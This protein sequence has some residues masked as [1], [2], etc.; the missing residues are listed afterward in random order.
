M[1]IPP[2]RFLAWLR[3]LAVMAGLGALS[4]QA[5]TLAINNDVN[6]YATLTNTTVTMTGR[7]EL[8][9]T[10]TSNP[11]S[12]STIN[13]NSPDA[14]FF[15]TNIQPTVVV[16][17]YLGQVKVN[18]AAAAAGSNCRVV[19][20]GVGAVVIPQGPTFSPM[21]VYD[22]PQFSGPS[23]ALLPQTA[24]GSTELGTLNDAISSFKLKRGYTAT[25]A[26]NP[27][28]TGI[29]KNYVAADGD[30]EVSVL[31]SNLDNSVSFVR[32]FP[33]RWVN[34]KGSCDIDPV[35]L[36]AKWHYNWNIWEPS[37]S[38]DYEYV[39]IKQQPYWPGLNTSYMNSLG[40]S[41]LSG[42]NEPNNPV[43]DAYKNLN[44]QG[45]VSAAVAGFP[46]LLSTGLRV[47]T[48]AVTD[49]GY[50]WIVNFVNQANAAGYRIDYVP[51]HYYRSYPNNSYPAGA[52]GNLYNFLKSIYD[53]TGKPIWLTEFNNG[54]NWTTDP[55][56]D[57]AQNSNVI[58]AM[59]NMM[60][61][62]PWI[63]RYA[64]YS[65]VEEVRQVYYNAGGLTPM[66]VMYRDHV[67]PMAYRQALPEAGG[68]VSARYPFDDNFRD[69]LGNGNDAMAVGTPGF[70]AGKFGQA[71]TMDGTN[72]YLQLSNGVGDSVD[73]TF[74][75]WVKWNGG[76]NWQ[77]IFDFGGGVY[78]PNASQGSY[79]MLT[80]NNGSG[81]RFAITT[82]GYSNEQALTRSTP[83]PTGTWT[84][85]AV[86]I[87]GNTGKLF[88][89]GALVATNTGMT[90]NPVDIGTKFNYLGKSQYSG[91]PLFNGQLD[92][93]QILDYALTDAQVAALFS[94]G[95]PQFVSSPFS[96]PNASPLAPYSSSIAGYALDP[97]GQTVSYSK[98]SGP[99]WLSVAPDGRLFGIPAASDVGANTF[100]IRAQDPAG[101]VGT[102]TMTISVGAS[103]GLLV[104]Y[105]FDGT[106]APTAG[107]AESVATGSPAFTTGKYSQALNFD[108]S[109]DYLTLP[110]DLAST[111]DITVATWVYWN[112]GNAWQRIFDFGDT[113]ARSM[114]LTPSSGTG[115]LTFT[116][117]N[118]VANQSVESTGALPVR[119]W[120]HV[121]VTMNGDVGKLFV[122][123]TLVATNTGMTLNPVDLGAKTNYLGKSQWS[124]D[125]LFSGRLDEFTIFNYAL[126]DAGVAALFS[127]QPPSFNPA[128]VTGPA[129]TP[130]QLYRHS[131]AGAATDPEGGALSYSKL[132]GPQWL[133]ASPNGTLYG[134]PEDG[135][136]GLNTFRV[137][138]TDP[139][140]SSADATF[141]M[142]VGGNALVAEY[143]FN[144]NTNDN[145]GSNHGTASGSPAYVPGVFDQAISLNG[146][147][148]YVTLPA[149]IANSA[150]MTVSAR[151]KWNGG[152]AWQRVFD[153]GNDTNQHIYF[154][155][156]NSSG[157]PMFVIKNGS[158][159]D[160][161]ITAP[162]AFPIG[163]WTHV[164][165][166]LGG[167]TGAIYIDGT[168]VA[169]GAMT[170]AP[171]SFNPGVNYIGKSQFSADPLFNGQIDDLRI[172]SRALTDP[173][174][175][176]LATAA[177]TVNPNSALAYDNW[178]STIGFAAGQDGP[179]NDP[180]G[181]GESNVWELLTGS[182][183][184]VASSTPSS[185]GVD[186][187]AALGLANP[188]KTYLTMK[189]R[190]LKNRS[191][192][193]IVPR[194]AAT[195]LG[196]SDPASSANVSQ[197]GAPVDA[198]AFEIITYYLNMPLED[199]PA[200]F[201]RLDIGV[202]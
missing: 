151:V 157:A 100:L 39:A 144:G 1:M 43:E 135:D 111:S 25:I 32:I 155:P 64:I 23:K 168:K 57:F 137:R 128:S 65:A 50:S 84:H 158:G 27:D 141:S 48:P 38:R 165:V 3:C 175:S 45:S 191:G 189:P 16:S 44:P 4:A 150:A 146:T 156:R 96:A 181:D 66:G 132:L 178:A 33:W 193:S 122:N 187:A 180:D 184:L 160:Q 75:A 9:I 94:N 172:Y 54:A 41:H 169:S 199:S 127:N 133:T 90:F 161:I 81:M 31:P 56:P 5:Q 166:S 13:L 15:M 52:A 129:G 101:N 188:G 148:D 202:Q 88:V 28:G 53:A 83:L 74:A 110:G 126:S 8:R 200:G 134:R 36:N 69:L 79:L 91:D 40:V 11:I 47:G 19:Q 87:S 118:E 105:A 18:G 147:S 71:V 116:I 167:G 42:L 113:T 164:A 185:L 125:P 197:A 80:P 170:L 171:S 62:T 196:L 119:R 86:T 102:A 138:A 46:E 109:D 114:F 123:G 35:A 192:I 24:Y 139:A 115:T 173:E 85:V 117:Y 78:V 21:T 152:G 124:A 179:N 154:T 76:N 103:Q 162:G 49:G 68:S 107:V 112:G 136:V 58:E 177:F 6:S 183:P 63:E 72:D 82:S 92:D 2:S 17:T 7:S 142:N 195:L 120:T 60:D 70:A 12:G 97:E 34:K 77:R 51:I 159:T 37:P 55:D 145:V 131:I 182:N 93:V 29:S 10:G 22:Y 194:G 61:S 176:N 14:W 108:A 26:Q 153:F 140:G 190:L 95:T 67:S 130:G 98:L 143:V 106:L 163:E 99:S 149:G 104:R 186:T 201:M 73:F 121:A 198:G 20:Y 89:D 30:L 59:I 174:A